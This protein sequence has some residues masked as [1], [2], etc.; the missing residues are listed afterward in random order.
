MNSLRIFAPAAAAILLLAA[1]SAHADGITSLKVSPLV[2]APNGHVEATVQG[3]GTC[4]VRLWVMREGPDGEPWSLSTQKQGSLPMQF[5]VDQSMKGAL[6]EG[7]YQLQ[8]ES[9]PN[10]V[11][12]CPK[13]QKTEIVSF[14]VDEP[15][16]APPMAA[17]VNPCPPG[18]SVIPGSA[19][20]GGAFTCKPVKPAPAQC[21]PKHEWFDDGCVAGCKPVVY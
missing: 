2:V 20:A 3:T 13:A 12:S 6:K 7:K 1:H 19:K 14:K 15:R 16:A 9:V 10:V 5:K 11:P 18:W 4:M 21:P 17:F 8:A